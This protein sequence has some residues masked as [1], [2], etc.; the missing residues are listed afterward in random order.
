M[1]QKIEDFINNRTL[2]ILFGIL[3]LST[4]L[5]L[6]HINFQ[7]LWIDE[8]YSI[9]P[10][11][12]ENSLQ[13]VI[14]YSKGDQPPLFFIY[15]HYIFKIFGYNEIVGRIACAFIGLLSIPIIYYLG[16]E[17]HNKATG[18]F[19]AL[20]TGVNYFHIYYSQE[21]RFYSMAFLFSTLS[22]LFFVRAFK[23]NDLINFV[24][25]A[26]FTIGLLY[27]HYYGMII[28]FGQGLT[29]IVLLKYK[30]DIKFIILSICAGLAIVAAFS[31]WLPIIFND[32]TDVLPHIKIPEPHFVIKYFYYYTGKDALTTSLFCFFIFLFFKAFYSYNSLS[33]ENK[34]VY[35]IVLIWIVWSYLFPYIR[36]ILVTPMLADRY[37]IITL[38]AWIILLALGW[39]K[40]R[41]L[42]LKYGFPIILVLSSIINLI[43][44]RQYYSIIKKDQWRDASQIVISKNYSH[45]P[46]YSTYPWHFSFYF[47]NSIDKVKDLYSADYA[48]DKQFWLLQAHVPEEEMESD[49]KQL[50]KSFEIIERHSFYGANAVLFKVK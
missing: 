20:L 41:N 14:E 13:S 16:K 7:S 37:T 6:Y 26:I 31:P 45:Y 27:I 30:R 29:F 50:N 42:K 47:R 34:S 4:L 21:L 44:F 32:L 3:A 28:F 8:L 39:E 17:C 18:V 5:R 2:Y 24:G 43:F 10:T 19:A 25:Y 15:L 36:S 48:S 46:V 38:P 12:P 49:I 40:M 9:V 11:A 1:V 23:R 35:L 33:I 22:Y